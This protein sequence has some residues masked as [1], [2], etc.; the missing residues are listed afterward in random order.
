M[1]AARFTGT[2]APAGAQVITSGI[3]DLLWDLTKSD[4]ASGSS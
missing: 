2:S 3:Y 1:Q 4:L